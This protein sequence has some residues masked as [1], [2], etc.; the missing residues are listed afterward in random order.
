[1]ITNHILEEKVRVQREL[2]KEADYDVHE[3]VENVNRI[4]KETEK[5]YGVKF[6]HYSASE[7]KS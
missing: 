2:A 5:Q 3:Y 7:V 6:K 1:M 4:V